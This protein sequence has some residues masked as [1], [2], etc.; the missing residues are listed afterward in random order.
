MKYLFGLFLACFFLGC[1]VKPVTVPSE[2]RV[3]Q[4][5]GQLVSLDRNVSHEEA[6]RLASDIFGYTAKLTQQYELVSPPMFHNFLVNTGMREG[7]LC[8]QW[9]DA[10]YAHLHANKYPSFE[11]H[12]AVANQGEYW[13]EHNAL[14]VAPKGGKVE[15]GIIIDPWR[16]SGN[17]FFEKFKKDS[18]YEWKH[19]LDRCGCTE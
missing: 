1:S 11:F 10:L 2:K 14:V 19:R 12:L 13:S 18:L 6:Q 5:V 16:H 4:L 8:Y 9:S 17:L 15:E 7:G 3:A